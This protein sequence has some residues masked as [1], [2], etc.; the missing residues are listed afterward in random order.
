MCAV[1]PVKLQREAASESGE[2]EVYNRRVASDIYV[3]G[4]PGVGGLGGGR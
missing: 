4:V 2:E 3:G 1:R